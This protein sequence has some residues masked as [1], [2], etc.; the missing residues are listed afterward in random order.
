MWLAI[1]HSAAFSFPPTYSISHPICLYSH[2]QAF[3][4]SPHCPSAMEWNVC[5]LRIHILNPNAQYDGVWRQGRWEA[6]RS[7]GLCLDHGI[8]T[9][10]KEA[11]ERLLIPSTMLGYNEKT[12]SMRMLALT[13]HNQ[14]HDLGLLASRI[15]RNKFLLFISQLAYGFFFAVTARTD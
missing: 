11:G 7:W 9:L 10:I 5:P 14:S 4:F 3:L 1:F 13:R 15:A 2:T 8:S 6:I 12:A